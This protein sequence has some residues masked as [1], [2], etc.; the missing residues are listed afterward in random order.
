[1]KDLLLK[2]EDLSLIIDD[3]QILENVSFLIERGQIITI[4]G[5]NGS[6]KTSLARCL[7][8]LIE[9]TSGYMWFKPGLRI[10]YMPQKIHFNPNLPLTVIDFLKL[11]VAQK[12]E[13]DLLFEVINET[14]INDILSRPLQKISGG[15]TQRVIL[16]RALLMKPNLLILDEPDQGVDINGQIELYQL[17][18]KLR[19]E[20][21]ISSL[22]ISHNLHMVMK[23]TDY[24]ICLNQHICCE[25]SPSFVNKQEEFHT[26]FGN[27]S[28]EH[29]SVYEHNHNH[30]HK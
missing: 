20:K 27:K 17:I 8:K 18:E 26:L 21:N 10:G 23:N 25:G 14:K 7:L 16:A 11:E 9:P 1:M 19:L 24:V 3:K 2:I 30:V 15:E 29:F 5:P 4:I 12:I 22:I 6:G 28:L 13:Q